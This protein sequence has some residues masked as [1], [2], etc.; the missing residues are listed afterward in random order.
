MKRI[1]TFIILS[2][3]IYYHSFKAEIGCMDNSWHLQKRYDYKEYHF[4]SCNCPCSKGKLLNDRGKCLSCQHYRDP[5]PFI[6]VTHND[7]PASSSKQSH[8]SKKKLFA[9]DLLKQ[10]AHNNNRH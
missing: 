4:V 7:Q 2:C 10:K 8:V 6:I 5:Q 9:I 3:S 1:I